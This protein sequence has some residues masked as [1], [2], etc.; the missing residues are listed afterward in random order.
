[1]SCTASIFGER[2]YYEKPVNRS[3]IREPVLVP[4]RWIA[5]AGSLRGL[6]SASWLPRSPAAA[7][8]AANL[9]RQIPEHLPHTNVPW[10]RGHLHDPHGSPYGAD[11][12]EQYIRGHGGPDPRPRTSL[13]CRRGDSN[14]REAVY[15][16]TAPFQAPSWRRWWS[17]GDSNPLPPPCKGGAL[18][19]ELQPH[20]AA[21]CG[22]G[23]STDT[24]GVS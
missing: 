19:D 16:A 6:Y 11:H 21:L 17:W 14:R 12:T 4:V 22:P 18:P 24:E 2:S 9:D 3:R 20:E 1:M 13:G 7:A 10:P 15:G 5:P 8:S 23:L